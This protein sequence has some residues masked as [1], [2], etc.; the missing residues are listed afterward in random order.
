MD[1]MNDSNTGVRPNILVILC[2]QLRRQALACYG[3]TDARTP[4]IDKLASNGVRFSNSCSSYPVCVPFR[5]TLMTGEHAHSRLIPAIEWAMSPTERTLAD[6]FNQNDYDTV[7]IGKWH[8]DGGHGRMGSARQCGRTP[9]RRS[10][11]GRWQH[12]FGFELRNDPFDTCYFVDDDP[13]PRPLDKY[14]TDGLFDI[15]IDYL[16]AKWDRKRNFCMVVSVEPPHDPF[17]APP[18]LQAEWEKRDIT[19]P[20]NFEA[21]DEKTREKLLLDRKRYYAMVE[22][23][24][25]NVGRM[26]SCLSNQ[27]L[28]ENTVIVFMS[29]HGELNGAHGLSEKQY[30]YEESVGIPLIVH[31]P[32]CP[33]RNGSVIEDPV[34]TEDLFPSILGLAGLTPKNHLPG[35]N[36]APLIHGGIPSLDREG[37]MLEFVSEHRPNMPFYKEV[38]RGIRTKRFK[39]T[40]KGDKFGGTPWQ[41]FDLDNDPCELN[42][43]LGNTQYQ[44]EIIRLHG[45]LAENI[46]QTEDPFVLLP[47]FGHAGVNLWDGKEQKA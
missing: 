45:I 38:W 35:I 46:R 22:N 13:E 37:V 24:D 5:F 31:D 16:S 1:S 15:G 21:K 17:V 4:N 19:L 47:A 8:L 26:V 3:D 12:W 20:L 2:D 18:E 34:C 42:N 27:G 29:D 10:S 32:R 11:Q 7:Y 39:Y 41:F 6:E 44:T 43:L 25:A 30:P 40:V 9:V 14:Q 36:L 28:A 33:A 23:L